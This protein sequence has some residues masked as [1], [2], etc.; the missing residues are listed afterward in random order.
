MYIRL[1]TT[2]DRAYKAYEG[3]KEAEKTM[4]TVLGMR[5]ADDSAAVRLKKLSGKLKDS[6][7]VLKDLFI[8]RADFRGYEDVSVRLNDRLYA[9]AGYISSAQMPGENAE[10]SLRNAIQATDA[11]TKRV[12]AFFE[13]E[14]KAFREE[15][16]KEK[17]RPFKDLGGY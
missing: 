7:E 16:E 17:T 11:I 5:Y 8:I 4:Q 2:V 6:L 13:K 14:W 3:L 9:A 1:K 10:V 15:A 12:N